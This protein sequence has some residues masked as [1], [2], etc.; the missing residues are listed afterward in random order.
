VLS[1]VY[2]DEPQQRPG[3]VLQAELAT[4]LP[5]LTAIN[6]D[7]Q[8]TAERLES[9]AA[10]AAA[11]DVVLFS[12]FVRTRHSKGGVAIAPPVASWLDQLAAG[13]PVVLTSFGSP[14][15]L[16]QLQRVGTRVLGWGGEDVS[17]RAA[18]RALMGEIDVTGRLPIH[19][20]PDHQ[21]GD[22][23]R[24]SG[25]SRSATSHRP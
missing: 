10:L 21:I 11:A 5:L 3:T 15:V 22:G 24:I 23:V 19:I 7:G 20:P 25:S 14:Y 18:V 8:A 1:I 4:R 6:L 12:S 16:S 2:T 9:V 17:Q 13:K